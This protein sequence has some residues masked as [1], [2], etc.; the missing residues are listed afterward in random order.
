MPQL[1]KL[2]ADIATELRLDAAEIAERKHFLELGDKDIVLLRE[3]HAAL[4][5]ERDHFTTA[6]YTHLLS[7]EPLRAMI[8]DETTLARLRDGQSRYFSAL[9]EG[10]YNERYVLDRLRVG[11]VHQ[12]INLA[13]KWYIG[14]YRKYL[15]ELLP[16]LVRLCDGEPERLLANID[17]LLKIVCFDIVIA[18]DTYFYHEHNRLLAS[19]RHAGQI[20]A[21]VPAG[22]LVLTPDLTI[23]Q[24]NPAILRMLGLGAADDPLGRRADELLL[25]PALVRLAEATLTGDLCNGLMLDRPGEDGMRHYRLD[26]TAT[27]LDGERALLLLLND[28]TQEHRSREATRQFRAML[29]LSPDAVLLFDRA[30]MRIADA[31]QA[32]CRSLGYT[33]DELLRLGPQDITPEHDTARVA[34][35]FDRI[36]AAPDSNHTLE[37][38]CRR[39]DGSLFPAEISRR[40]VMSDGQAIIIAA[41][42]DIG[43]R[44]AAEEEIQR[45]NLDLERRVLERT[46]ELEAAN[47]ELA[48]FSYTLSHDLRAPLR[49]IA[50]YTAILQDDYGQRLDET[51]VSHLARIR[52]ATHRMDGLIDDMLGLFQIGAKTLERRKIDLGLIAR[53]ILERLSGAEP[54]RRVDWRVDPAPLATGDAGWLRS[55]LENLLD[56][57]WKYTSH[58]DDATI[59]FG[60]RCD[61]N[62][63]VSYFI[64]D[65]GAGFDMRYADK[66]FTPFQRLHAEKEFPGNG[67]GLA[68]VRRIV[69]LHGGEVWAEAAPGQGATFFF[70][71][72]PEA[73]A[74]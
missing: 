30:T 12:R 52:R 17:A 60:A 65:N 25:A 69:R 18:V 44:K 58:R 54:G 1:D 51:G 32:A 21:N 68:T 71:L 67:I 6:F 50:G 16:L 72:L 26:L 49:G 43:E 8:G 56:N 11:V 41:A 27:D 47:T 19:Q 37:T 74:L 36:L 3:M 10:D 57:A 13:P 48:A 35:E 66:L 61:A 55:L 2:T 70:T 7:Y 39:K 45:L 28:V 5:A 40:G 46:A 4:E 14:A 22:I 34:A 73:P 38:V 31:N 63:R 64:R 24:A 33:L 23:R 62:G 59:E 53:E 29:D 42:R 15:S 9:T 20:L